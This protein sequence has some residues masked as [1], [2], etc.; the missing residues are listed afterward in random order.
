V[1]QEAEAPG[2]QDSRQVKVVRLSALRTD[3]PFPPG[4]I[5]GTHFCYR[6]SPKLLKACMTNIV[7][8]IMTKMIV[9]FKAY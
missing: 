9:K 7:I 2:F 5:P 6:L 1:F 3:R 8:V 4:N